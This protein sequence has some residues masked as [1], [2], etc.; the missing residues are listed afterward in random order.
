MTKRSSPSIEVLAADNPAGLPVVIGIPFRRGEV[1]ELAS[2]H[3][4]GPSGKACPLTARALNHWPDGSARWIS[5]TA[6]AGECGQHRITLAKRRGK[7][8]AVPNAVRLKNH[9]NTATIDNGLVKIVLGTAGP[10][11]IH[12]I[13]GLGHRYLGDR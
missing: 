2:L 7:S 9:S 3:M 5:L 8:A 6:L 1:R 13:S 12:E 10:G 11:P 4:T